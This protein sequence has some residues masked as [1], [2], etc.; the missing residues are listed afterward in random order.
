MQV[1]VDVVFFEVYVFVLWYVVFGDVE[2]VYDFEVG[3]DLLCCV[4]GKGVLFVQ[5]IV[6]VV[7]YFDGVFGGFDVN[8]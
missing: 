6:D 4:F 3:Y 2:V 8:V 1:E 5:C 7:V